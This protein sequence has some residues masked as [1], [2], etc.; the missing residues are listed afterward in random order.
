MRSYKTVLITGASAGFGKAISKLLAQQGYKVIAAA[1]RIDK[2][3]TLAAECGANV[4]PL[5][6]D[7]CSESSVA[8][9]F[10]RLPENLR[11]IDVLVNNAGLALGQD[12]AQDCDFSD[13]QTM[14]DTNITGLLR[15]THKILP[16]MVKRNLG[17]IINLGSTAGSWPYTGGNVYGG[18]KAFVAQ[19]SRNLRTDLADTA[20]KVT[21]I[22]PGLCS[23]TEFSNVRF[24][25]D[26]SKAEAV[27]K[28]TEA[29]LPEDI[30]DTVLWLLNGPAHLNIND[31]EMMP[32]C[33]SFGGL[34]VKRNLNLK[35][36]AE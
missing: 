11:C 18:T 7:V 17:Y 28:D 20:V 3:Q 16:Q 24:K 12:K 13:W 23:N 6:L 29:I 5:E 32:V 25:G 10:D 30:A 14:V 19:F 4:Y 35:P 36:A 33:Q 22:R 31:I 2:L 34:S 26:E 21:V 15:L 27:Y 9:L 1:R 8:S